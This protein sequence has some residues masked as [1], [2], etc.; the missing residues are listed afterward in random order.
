MDN[1][2][3]KPDQAVQPYSM[4][5]LMIHGAFEST[6]WDY[7]DHIVPPISASNAYR[8]ESVARG[9]EGFIKF[10]NPEFKLDHE[11]RDLKDLAAYMRKKGLSHLLKI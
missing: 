5:T 8:L 1:K 7:S 9:A 2:K 4:E 11:F 6:A 3:A 10:A